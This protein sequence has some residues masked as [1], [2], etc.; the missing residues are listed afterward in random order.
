VAQE[1]HI[2]ALGRV[3]GVEIAMLCDTR[4]ESAEAALREGNLRA[5]ITTK[6]DDMSGKVDAAIVAVPPRFHA[7]TT[8][9]LL[10]MGIDVMCEKPLAVTSQEGHEM[11]AAADRAGRILAAG[12][13]TRF[14]RQNDMLRLALRDPAIGGIREIVAEYG[15][16]LAWSMTSDVY[17]NRQFTGGGVFFDAGVHLLDRIIW[18]FGDIELADYADDSF[19]G[20]ESNAELTGTISVGNQKVPC[21]MAFSWT[22][23]LANSIRLVCEGAIVEATIRDSG[24]LR[25]RRQ[26]DGQWLAMRVES[27]ESSAEPF[28]LQARDFIA[29]VRERRQPLVTGASALGALSVIEQAY[30]RRRPLSQPW[31]EWSPAS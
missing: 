5:C 2:P 11:V 23:V 15:S 25:I 12:M 10:E 21:R 16:Q 6:L 17:Y 28:D 22:H 1:F 31:M 24:A 9:R 3:P 26:V 4:R 30:A 27:P 8:I 7:A 19:G 13:V 18:L 14:F 20:V 29:A